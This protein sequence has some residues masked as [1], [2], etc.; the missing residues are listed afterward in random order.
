[1]TR[2]MHYRNESQQ[3][4]LNHPAPGKAGIASL[5]AIGHLCLGL[6]EPGR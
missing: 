4:G 5:F 1:M 6:P 2:F 3:V